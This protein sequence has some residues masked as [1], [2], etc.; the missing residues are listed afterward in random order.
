MSAFDEAKAQVV[1]AAQVLELS[2]KTIAS[3]QTP[4]RVIK[5][6]L[7]IKMDNGKT[8]S[9]KA[10][11]S[12]HNK[13]LGPYKGGIRYHTNV[14]EDEVKALS[15]WMSF[16]TA[17]A[18]I[19]YGGAKGGI[20]LD[21]KKLSS[22]ELE[23]LSR[24]YGKAFAP[25]IGP[26]LDVPAPDV[27]TNGQIMAWMV[28]EY[29]HYLSQKGLQGLQNP[30]ATFTGKPII[31]GGSQGR[32]EATGLGGFYVLQQLAA[33]LGKKPKELRVA[34][35]GF[36]NV[37]YWFAY[38][39]NQAG[40]K[41]VSVSN[42]REGLYVDSGLDPEEVMNRL[43]EGESLADC[44]GNEGKIISNE[45]LLALPVDILVPA[46]IDGVLTKTNIG[47]VKASVVLELANGPMT[48]EA[49]QEFLKNSKNI[50]VPD[51]LA[52]AGGVVTSYF[53]WVQNL[54]GYY[55]GKEEVFAKLKTIMDQAFANVWEEYQSRK[56]SMRIAAYVV[57]LKRLLE[58]HELLN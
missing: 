10:F 14:S 6:T 49:E 36:G 45:E 29:E 12:Q 5:K 22:K 26:W 54:Q 17:V 31:L 56:V 37:A 55:W 35:Q 30:R 48:V 52:N 33:K 25:Y 34:V 4:D 7:T 3:L 40:Y 39:A 19:P 44:V 38:F 18:G 53:E 11:R 46:A 58:A 32:E 47:K 50:V 24:E 20:S 23:A 21:P 43:Q 13:Y 41:V 27:N 42:S 28:D 1:Q 57:A 9:Y 8:V 15:L 2:D 16:K 51:I